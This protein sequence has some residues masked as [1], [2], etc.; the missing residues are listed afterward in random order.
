M[1]LHFNHKNHPVQTALTL[2]WTPLLSTSLQDGRSPETN[3]VRL[4]FLFHFLIKQKVMNSKRMKMRSGMR[5]NTK[6]FSSLLNQT[7][8]LTPNFQIIHST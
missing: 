3:S 1:G 2:L 4:D 8:H 6:S 5:M 7:H